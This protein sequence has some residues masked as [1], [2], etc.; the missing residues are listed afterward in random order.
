MPELR[1][2]DF[3]VPSE[4]NPTAPLDCM[5]SDAMRSYSAR[6]TT[7]SDFLDGV[8]NISRPGEI[9]PLFWIPDDVISYGES[10]EPISDAIRWCHAELSRAQFPR[11]LARTCEFLRVLIFSARTP[12]GIYGNDFRKVTF[13]S[14]EKL[15]PGLLIGQEGRSVCSLSGAVFNLVQKNKHRAN[16][17]VSLFL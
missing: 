17:S 12:S 14:L 16:Q 5:A 10:N 3:V 2:T 15:P 6:T 4:L 8:A 7:K 11:V 1:T 9:C 13:L